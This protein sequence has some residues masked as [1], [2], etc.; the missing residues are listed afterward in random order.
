V[1]DSAQADVT[2][3]QRAITSTHTT[4]AS[5]PLAAASSL[6]LVPFVLNPPLLSYLIESH[7]VHFHLR[8]SVLYVSIAVACRGKRKTS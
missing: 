3:C 2:I 1:S 6:S 8:M 7:L 5:H 4:L